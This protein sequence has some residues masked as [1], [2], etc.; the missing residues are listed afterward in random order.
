MERFGVSVELSGAI[1]VYAFREQHPDGYQE[2]AER[3]RVHMRLGRPPTSIR[4]IHSSRFS[5][6]AASHVTG[7]K[8]SA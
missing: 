8:S 4:A 2:G 5:A 7:P 1:R 6:M 3:A